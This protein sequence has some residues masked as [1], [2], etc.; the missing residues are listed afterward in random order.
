LPK[1]AAG[2][3]Q[4]VMNLQ[5]QITGEEARGV[6]SRNGIVLKVTNIPVGM[7]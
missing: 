6:S 7:A 3:I 5:G 1:F 2:Q 4:A